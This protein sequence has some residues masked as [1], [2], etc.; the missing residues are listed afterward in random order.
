MLRL[1]TAIIGPKIFALS[2]PGLA[3]YFGVYPLEFQKYLPQ[4][5]MVYVFSIFIGLVALKIIVLE[6]YE[7]RSVRATMFDLSLDF[8]AALAAVW[9][10]QE[11]LH[12]D[13]PTG[14]IVMVAISCIILVFDFFYSVFK[15]VG[16]Y[17]EVDEPEAETD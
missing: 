5:W 14:L 3:F 16:A 11:L 2:L 8:V 1:T 13:M 10:L 6:N 7:D 4:T 12:T 9:Y 15:S 17:Q